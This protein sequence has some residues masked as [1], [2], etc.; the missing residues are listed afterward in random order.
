VGLAGAAHQ[1][2]N[3]GIHSRGGGGGG[4]GGRGNAGNNGGGEAAAAAM[5][6]TKGAR[7]AA[8]IAQGRDS[9]TSSSSSSS[10]GDDV[11]S[12]LERVRASQLRAADHLERDVVSAEVAVAT[13][14]LA[15]EVDAKTARVAELEARL[16]E[17]SYDCRGEWGAWGECS[18][19]CGGGM[20]SRLYSVV[21]EAERGRIEEDGRDTSGQ[22][23]PHP[24]KHVELNKCNDHECAAACEGRWGEWGECSAPCGRGR[25]SRS[26][27]VAAPARGAGTPCPHDHN[28]TEESFCSSA[29][30]PSDCPG[31]WDDWSACAADCGGGGPGGGVGG[32]GGAVSGK[33]HRAYDH[34][35]QAEAVMRDDGTLNM[36]AVS[37]RLCPHR[38]GGCTS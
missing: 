24:D 17:M 13:H 23:C 38:W 14:A 35:E 33:Q 27:A 15:S 10:S 5:H 31:R 6:Q 36:Q 34:P 28:H 19:S 8:L 9:T 29:K 32:A 11:R 12:T 3:G 20:R 18:V 4:G 21:K 16:S 7:L 25:K 1:Q 26:Y 37:K 22:A 30:C 2:V